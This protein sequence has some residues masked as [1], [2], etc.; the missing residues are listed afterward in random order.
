[1]P[2]AWF[3]SQGSYCWLG[4]RSWPVRLRFICVWLLVAYSGQAALT[5]GASPRDLVTTVVGGRAAIGAPARP[6]KS[7]V[8][9][10]APGPSVQGDTP[11]RLA[12]L[13]EPA[14][15]GQLLR[16]LLSTTIVLACAY[17]GCVGGAF[18]LT[19]SPAI[20]TPARPAHP[21]PVHWRVLR[22]PLRRQPRPPAVVARCAVAALGLLQILVRSPGGWYRHLTALLACGLST[23]CPFL[24]LCT[25]SPPLRCLALIPYF[26]RVTSALQAVGLEAQGSGRRPLERRAPP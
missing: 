3:C 10:S 20:R 19:Q 12:R 2:R 13:G 7:V 23:C 26:A 4:H 1:M 24:V 8:G 9:S 17:L 22:L 18:G 14:C 21:L 5:T 15:G 6:P 25:S 11:P 16:G